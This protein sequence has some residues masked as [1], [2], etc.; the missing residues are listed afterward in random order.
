MVPKVNR[1]SLWKFRVDFVGNKLKSSEITY[2]VQAAGWRRFDHENL[3]GWHAR[4]KGV[5]MQCM[6]GKQEEA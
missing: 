2:I 1:C 6:R 5:N 3:R 4:R